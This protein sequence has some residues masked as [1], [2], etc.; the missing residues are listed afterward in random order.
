[1]KVLDK[2]NLIF[3][4]VLISLVCFLVFIDFSFV[5]DFIFYIVF[6]NILTDVI[7]KFLIEKFDKSLVVLKTILSTFIRLFFSI[8]FILFFHF[9]G[10]ENLLNF[11]LNF[12]I[13]YLL[14]IIF[15]ITI[16]LL[17]LHH[18]K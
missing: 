17:N 9:Y 16:L 4:L 1:M 3:Y 10:I 2:S 11:I 15:E 5:N 7:F 18:I 12:L 14:F 8:I 13:V 6:F